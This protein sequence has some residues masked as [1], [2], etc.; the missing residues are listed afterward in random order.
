MHVRAYNVNFSLRAN[1]KCKISWFWFRAEYIMIYCKA[2][3]EKGPKIDIAK[4]A[5][6]NLALEMSQF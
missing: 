1:I 6:I 2:L 5:Q 4:T 3:H